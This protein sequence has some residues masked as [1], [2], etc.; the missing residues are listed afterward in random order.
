LKLVHYH[1]LLREM[2]NKM[3][4]VYASTSNYRSWKTLGH[5]FHC[6]SHLWNI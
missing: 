3:Y 6:S 2:R 5:F 1:I 4:L